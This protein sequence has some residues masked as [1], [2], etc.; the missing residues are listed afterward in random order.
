M[1]S[2]EFGITNFVVVRKKNPNRLAGAFRPSAF[3]DGNLSINGYNELK[4]TEADTKMRDSIGHSAKKQ[5][6]SKHTEEDE[7]DEH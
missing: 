7:N 1:A 2:P 3:I 5:G 4:N 6:K